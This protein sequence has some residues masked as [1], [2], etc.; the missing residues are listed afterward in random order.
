MREILPQ[1]SGSTTTADTLKEAREVAQ[2]FSFKVNR[3]EVL[4]CTSY[5]FQ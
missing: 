5:K 2:Q 1:L 4:S 3:K